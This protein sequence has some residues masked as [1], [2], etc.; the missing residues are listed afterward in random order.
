M[1]ARKKPAVFLSAVAGKKDVALPPQQQQQQHDEAERNVVLARCPRLRPPPPRLGRRL[2]RRALV[3]HPRSLV[4][5]LAFVGI[6]L[7]VHHRRRRRRRCPQGREDQVRIQQATVHFVCQIPVGK[8]Q[9]RERA[10]VMDG[11]AE[12][13]SKAQTLFVEPPKPRHTSGFFFVE[14]PFVAWGHSSFPKKGI[15]RKSKGIIPHFANSL[16]GGGCLEW[17]FN[18]SFLL[19]LLLFV[20]REPCHLLGVLA[21][22]PPPLLLPFHASARSVAA[23]V[24]FDSGLH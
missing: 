3:Q 17:G 19:L 4:L 24:G 18:A 16:R 11:S 6:L 20:L 5:L 9:H 8:T 10:S 23:I 22:P 12:E 7:L 15:R 1:H 13:A 2:L 21:I 14:K